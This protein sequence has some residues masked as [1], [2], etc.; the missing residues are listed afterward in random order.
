M[1]EVGERGGD[2]CCT[3]RWISNN[4]P[5]IEEEVREISGQVKLLQN[6]I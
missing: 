6:K 3:D 2:R 4:E 1:A 5:Q